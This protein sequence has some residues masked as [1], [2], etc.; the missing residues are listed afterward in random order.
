MPSIA[1]LIVNYN[2]RDLLRRALQSVERLIDAH[3]ALDI[4]VVDNASSDGSGEMVCAEFPTVHLLQLPVNLGFTGG[5]NLA[6]H[7]LGF[8]VT[9]PAIALSAAAVALPPPAVAQPEFVLLLNPDAELAEDALAHL[10]ATMAQ[11]PRAAI[12]GARLSYGDGRFQHGAFQFPNLFQLWLDF[13]PLTHLPG[14]HRLQHS[15]WNGRY[16]PAQ[17]HGSDPFAVDFV[18]G[19]VMLVRGAA[20]ES[21]GGLDPTYFMYCEEM[22]WCA[23]MAQQDW[24][25]FAVPR[26]KVIHH[27][28][29]SSKQVRWES[30]VRMWRSR[31]YFYQKHRHL[32]PV[33]YLYLV[34]ATVWV[35]LQARTKAAWRA[36]QQGATTGR[37]LADEL[38]A[39]ET[40]L[41]L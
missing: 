9:D 27:E 7:L 38:A 30:Y 18:L 20:I 8:T 10:V 32:Y 13:F 12:C 37:Q 16:A 1:V 17:W 26:A 21:V 34:R 2:T 6:L 24:Q 39:Y 29:Q 11:Q 5:N 28:G 4:W 40:I 14:A 15:G 25:I 41:R 36:F 33:G 22:D 19:A 23:R 35:G 3:Q 31:Y